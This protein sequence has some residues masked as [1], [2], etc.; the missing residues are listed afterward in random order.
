[1]ICI[2]SIN[3]E[4]PNF[5]NECKTM[6]SSKYMSEVNKDVTIKSYVNDRFSPM[7]LE[8]LSNNKDAAERIRRIVVGDRQEI[9]ISS[10]NRDENK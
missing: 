10:R 5:G 3:I 2:V 8:Y 1:M 7:L 4:E 6:L 9:E